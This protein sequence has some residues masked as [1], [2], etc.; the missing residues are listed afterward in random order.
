[1]RNSYIYKV[2]ILS[3]LSAC[4]GSPDRDQQS[5]LVIG[6]SVSIGY[7]S[8]IAEQVPD[9][10]VIHNPKNG[11]TSRNGAEKVQAWLKLDTRWDICTFNHGL[12]D[13]ADYDEA[14]T[15]IEDYMT[16]LYFIGTNL[17]A[18]C[19][20]VY[21]ILTTARPQNSASF[22]IG[23]VEAY[24]EAAKS[25]MASLEIPIIDLHTKSLEIEHMHLR[26]LE[27][28]DV[29]FTEEGSSALATFIVESIRAF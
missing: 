5:W 22:A 19:G 4:A 21:F 1:M 28:D 18:A 12:W 2:L 20:E 13:T 23:E 17:Q 25:V 6:D 3:L 27:Q 26:A 8:Y 15:T 7:T 9:V 29:H 24:N 16:N 11:Q 14:G 10:R